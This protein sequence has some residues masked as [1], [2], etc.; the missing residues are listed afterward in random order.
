MGV[1]QVDN[2]FIHAE[3]SFV[4]DVYF[5]GATCIP[6]NSNGMMYLIQTMFT[7]NFA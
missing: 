7:L 5:Y 4:L 1:S 2:F 3:R 6:H